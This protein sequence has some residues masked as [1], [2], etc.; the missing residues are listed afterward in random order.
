MIESPLL[1]RLSAP[2]SIVGHVA[3]VILALLY[4]DAE[5]FA[6]RPSEAVSVDIVTPDEVEVPPPK[7]A[8]D[9]KPAE[10]QPD[11]IDF[12]ALT[13]L[14]KPQIKPDGP[15]QQAPQPKS[16]GATKPQSPPDAPAG[17]Q[18]ASAA[19][20]AAKPAGPDALQPTSAMPTPAPPAAAQAPT[21][22]Q[23]PEPDITVKYG[24]MLGLPAQNQNDGVDAPALETAKVAVDDI[25]A[26]RR[27]LKSCSSLPPGVAPTD[28]VRI[29]LRIVLT[30]DGRLATEPSL[31]EASA[32][33]KGPALMQ[34]AMRALQTCQPYT[35]LPPDKY[36][37]WKVLDL[38]FTPQDFA[39]GD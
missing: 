26:F 8:D 2:A 19:Q 32:S 21:L 14:N 10:K 17:S 9:P 6:P 34:N 22:P 13:A 20:Q 39:G 23:A 1:M 24:V 33:V 29:V 36:D 38:A 28:K 5:P 27:H 30:R 12:S 37:E 15:G 11:P 4:A 16:Q 3:V 7:P 18:Q 35:M 31:I 25:A